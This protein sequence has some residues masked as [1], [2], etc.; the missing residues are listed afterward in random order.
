MAAIPD[1]NDKQ[2]QIPRQ[3]LFEKGFDWYSVGHYKKP[4]LILQ[5]FLLFCLKERLQL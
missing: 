4:K 2:I 3:Q 1:F 5:C